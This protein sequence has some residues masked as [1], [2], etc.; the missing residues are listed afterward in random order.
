MSHR[1]AE[2]ESFRRYIVST[3]RQLVEA[4]D[5][6]DEQALNWRPPAQETNSLLAIVTHVLG[7]TEE[8][9]LGTLCGVV[10]ERDRDG[11]F[12]TRAT[13]SNALREKWRLLESEIG[14][15]LAQLAPSELDRERDHPRRGRLTGR[16]VL[17]VV[18]RHAAEHWGEAQLTLSLLRAHR[19]GRS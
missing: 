6:L 10:V 4:L 12:A 16:E 8:N 14:V 7:N 13:S 2:V 1:A 18:A 11:E 19:G 15:T 3:I 9:L 17:L 5:G